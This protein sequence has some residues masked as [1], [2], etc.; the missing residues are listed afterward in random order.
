MGAL[1]FCWYVKQLQY[2]R[3]IPSVETFMDVIRILIFENNVLNHLIFILQLL[4]G[5]RAFC[6]EDDQGIRTKSELQK[7]IDH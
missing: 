7:S 2:A 5:S 4:D 1:F 6:L 3:Y